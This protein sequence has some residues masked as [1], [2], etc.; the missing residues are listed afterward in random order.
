CIPWSWYL[1]NDM[2]FYVISPLLMVS[3]IRWPIIGYSLMGLF[4]GI[5]YIS[6][7]VLT[8]VYNFPIGLVN[9]AKQFE[10]FASF[11]H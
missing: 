3:L 10:N 9:V 2:Q 8:Y 6:N 1:A 4:F 11:A 7:F 5:V